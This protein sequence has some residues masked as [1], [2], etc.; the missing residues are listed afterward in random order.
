VRK[1][2]EAPTE[3]TLKGVRDRTILTTLLYHGMRREELCG[4]RV[5]AMQS[6][7]GV[8]HFRVKG[9][10]GKIRFDPPPVAA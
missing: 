3:D 6:R 8:V 2:L 7:Q 10:R 9:K 4:L 5:H 1:L